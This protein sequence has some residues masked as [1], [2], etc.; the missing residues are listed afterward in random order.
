MRL[1]S[2]LLAALIAAAALPAVAQDGAALFAAKCAGCHK[3]GPKST[4]SG[5]SLQGVFGRPIA[6]LADFAYSPGLKAKSSG[7]WT[8]ANLEAFLGSPFTFA[9]GAAM[10]AGPFAAPE[11]AAIIAYLKA[12]P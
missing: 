4:P 6:G 1:S 2:L 12:H 3:A 7:K 5:P 9:P 10:Y 11:R 8:A